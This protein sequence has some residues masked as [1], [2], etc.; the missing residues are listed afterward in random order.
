MDTPGNR[1]SLLVGPEDD[2]QLFARKAFSGILIPCCQ[3]QE[4]IVK[5]HH[6]A[7][8]ICCVFCI[9]CKTPAPVAEPAPVEPVIEEKIDYHN[10]EL[11]C[12]NASVTIAGTQIRNILLTE[13]PKTK[14]KLLV[15]I[16]IDDDGIR[17]ARALIR[18][19][20]TKDVTIITPERMLLAGKLDGE[21]TDGT[22]RVASYSQEVAEE[23]LELM[24]K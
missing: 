13:E 22:I 15:E 5:I 7:L 21:I 4:E 17:T 10:I 9:G 3:A 16:H 8:L 11:I 14:K 24:T 12:G 18:K 20:N 19:N 6:L 1:G 23:I 2:Y